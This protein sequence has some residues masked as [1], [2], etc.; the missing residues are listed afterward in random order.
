[1]AQ[2]PASMFYKSEGY[3]VGAIKF[4]LLLSENHSIEAQVTEHPIE[5]G[6]PVHDHVR[7]LPR[8]GSLTGLV[9]NHPLKTDAKLPEWFLEK[10]QAAGQAGLL[11]QF[12]RQYGFSQNTLSQA[13]FAR[14]QKPLTNRAADTWKLFQVLVKTGEPVTISM[15]LEKPE[16]V[17]VT[18]VSTSRDSDTGDAQKFQVEF[19]EVRIVKLTEIKITAA[20]SPIDPTTAAKKALKGKVGGKQVNGTPKPVYSYNGAVKTVEIYSGAG[21]GTANVNKGQVFSPGGPLR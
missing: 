8:K 6:S 17:I 10:V 18:K 15:G 9:T 4:D 19:Q 12:A 20:T 5:D 7:I 11:T 21:E 14:L 3:F 13:D 1:M 2:V 16:N